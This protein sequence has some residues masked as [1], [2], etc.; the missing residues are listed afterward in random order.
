MTLARGQISCENG[1]G[2]VMVVGV[3]VDAQIWELTA[4][5]PPV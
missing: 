4:T 5:Q 2:R 1:R 3:D